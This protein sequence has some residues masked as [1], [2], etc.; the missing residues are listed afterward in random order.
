MSPKDLTLVQ[1]SVLLALMIKA[2]PLPN[3]FLR[4]VAKINLDKKYRD[5][6][7]IDRLITVTDR[8][9]V[10]ELTEKGW[11]EAI[12][13]LGAETPARAGALG[14]TLY[15]LLDVLRDHFDRNEIAPSQFFTARVAAPPAADP[16]AD[17]ETR[18]RAAYAALAQKPG[19]FV[20]LEAIRGELADA[21]RAE[22][23]TI[24]VE[25]NRAADVNLIPES[26]QKVLTAAERAAAVTIGN[27]DKHLIAIGS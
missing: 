22:V 6:L 18:V 14:G 24:L 3:A 20:M 27:Q 9:L 16:V 25:L 1:R 11:G 19:D 26:N 7:V 15:L 10:L 8:P 12:K 21:P 2:A 13:E 23:D 4:N 5:Q 17:L